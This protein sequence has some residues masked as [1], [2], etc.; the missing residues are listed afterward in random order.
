MK[1]KA[2][3]VSHCNALSYKTFCLSQCS[4]ALDH[5]RHKG[6]SLACCLSSEASF[7][8]LVFLFTFF[9][10]SC[11]ELIKLL[12]IFT[13]KVEY[14]HLS[15]ALKQLLSCKYQNSI[16]D[17][18]L[19]THHCSSFDGWSQVST[20]PKIFPTES[21]SKNLASVLL[22]WT[23]RLNFWYLVTSYYGELKL[24]ER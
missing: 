2:G 20:S 14:M 24:F 17:I 15:G 23:G 1:W 22:A 19:I 11:L 21:P 9:R 5:R 6:S 4:A 10:I 13:S 7:S 16:K 8:S 3:F 18:Q 12:M